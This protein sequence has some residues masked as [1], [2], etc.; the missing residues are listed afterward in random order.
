MNINV[1]LDGV[2]R[3]TIQRIHY[4]YLD[5][6]IHS[7]PENEN[8]DFEYGIVDEENIKNDNL[9]NYFKFQSEEEFKKFLYV[10]FPVEI[11]GHAAPSYKQV[12][13]DL[14]QLIFDYEDYE[15]NVVGVDNFLRGKPSSLFFLSKTAYLGNLIKFIRKEDIEKE[16]EKCDIWITDDKEVINLCPKDKIAIKFNTKYNDYFVHDY[17]INKL[18]EIKE[19]WKSLEKTTT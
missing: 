3:N 7:E 2:L 5:Y 15:F 16:W 1:S 9:M 19:I 10:D 17:E 18:T 8:D 13:N 11:F 14:N 12:V 4:H 6:F